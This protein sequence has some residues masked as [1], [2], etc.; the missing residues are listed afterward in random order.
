MKKAPEIND[1]DR[2][3]LTSLVRQGLESPTVEIDHWEHAPVSYINTEEANL[4]IHRFK[5][6]AQDKGEARPWSIVLKAVHAPIN[7]TD[8]T[9]WNY[10]R[11]EILAYQS[12]LLAGLPGGLSAPRC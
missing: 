8:Q 10:H 2:N 1:I 4:G 7:H 6:T 12:G 3:R 5:G 11:R 9:F